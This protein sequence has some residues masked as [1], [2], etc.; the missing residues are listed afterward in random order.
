MKEL[1]DRFVKHLALSIVVVSAGIMAFIIYDLSLSKNSVAETIV[2]KVSD[3]VYAELH[4][5]FEPIQNELKTTAAQTQLRGFYDMDSSNLTQL[6][7]PVI[8]SFPH[9][10]SMGI[11]DEEGVEFSIIKD[12][13]PGKWLTRQ[14]NNEQW[15]KQERW[16]SFS[17]DENYKKHKDSLWYSDLFEDPRSS[18]WFKGAVK[19]NR[20]TLFWSKPY[21]RNDR[22]ELNITVSTSWLNHQEVQKR[23]ILSYDIRLEDIS[24]FTNSL[25]PTKNGEV[26]ILSGDKKQVIGAPR[27]YNKE[28]HEAILINKELTEVLNHPSNDRP[29]RYKSEGKVW[30]GVT[31]EFKLNN[32]QSFLIVIALPENDFLKEINESQILMY[33][34][35]LGILILSILILRSHNKQRRQKRA[36]KDKNEE[37]YKQ[38]AV[39][40]KKNEEIVDSINY[41]RRIQAAILPPIRLVNNY[42]NNSFVLYLPKDIVAG[43]FYWMESLK[44]KEGEDLILFA[45]ADCTGHGVP[46]AMV[47]VMCHNALN[48]SV[49]EFDY[50]KPNKILDKSRELVVEEFSKSDFAMSDGMDISLCVLNLKNLKLSW[51]GANNP[52]WIIRDRQIIEY[53]AD[54]Q[55]VGNYI[56][57]EPFT[58]HYIQ[59][60]KGDV[61]YVFSDGIQD[62]FGGPKGKK[63]KV[64]QLKDLLIEVH[65]LN[66]KEQ[67]EIIYERIEKWRGDQEQVDDICLIGVKL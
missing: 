62:Q 59:L 15:G 1:L 9:I 29:I 47:S 18:I 37:I 11:A 34:G 48:R 35:F 54:K 3:R 61:I 31:K 4:N 25:M 53:K 41:A 57:N 45:A 50:I 58:N 26:M 27:G 51:A 10:T 28:D 21:K 44:S 65:Q 20:G 36:L 17:L 19:L 22:N 32:D 16:Y 33:G 56:V 64:T 23:I 67:H 55:P 66:P 7:I 30:W 60:Q 49:R 8:I 6:F 43:D 12:T 24:D 5:Y 63:F 46:G 52:L 39:I 14:I 13:T 40:I 2:S 38:K 42:L